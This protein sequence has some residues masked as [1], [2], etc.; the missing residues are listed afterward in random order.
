MCG[1]KAPMAEKRRPERDMRGIK[2]Y[3]GG[4]EAPPGRVSKAYRENKNIIPRENAICKGSC[5]WNH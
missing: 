2:K 5:L 3:P 4:L 1:Q